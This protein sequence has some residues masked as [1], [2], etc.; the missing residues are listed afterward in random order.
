MKRFSRTLVHVLLISVIILSVCLVSCSSESPKI[1]ETTQVLDEV[2]LNAL[3]GASVNSSTLSFESTTEQLSS[4]SVGDV[5]VCGVSNVTPYGLLRKVTDIVTDDNQMT[6]ETVNAT[7]G[8]AIQDCSLDTSWRLQSDGSFAPLLTNEAGDSLATSAEALAT[9]YYL[10][11][12]GVVLYD[13]DGNLDTKDDQITTDLSVDLNIDVDIGWTISWFRLTEAH[14]QATISVTSE[15]ETSCTVAVLEIHPKLE[16]YRQYL[17]AFTVM[18][19]PVPVVIL[20]MLSINIG[21][22][23][24]LSAGITAGVTGN[25]EMTVGVQYLDGDWSPIADFSTSFDWQEPSLTAGCEVKVSAGPQL[26]LLLYGQA[27]P[28]VE[29]RGYLELDADIFRT[30]WWELYGGLEADVGFKVEA[31]SHTIAD[32]E[33]PL[34]I[35]YRLLLAQAT[36]ELP[37]IFPDPNLEA[38]IREAI[39]KPTGDIYPSDLQGLTTFYGWHKDITDLTGLEYCT[40]LAWLTFRNNQISDISPLVDNSGLGEGDTVDLRNNPLSSQSINLYIPQL[41]DRGITVYYVYNEKPK[42]YS[43]PP[44]MI[45]DTSKQYIATIETEKGNLVLELFAN[46]V[47]VTVNNF[48]FLAY[49]GFY[50]GLTFH[51][52]VPDFVAQ[53]GCPIGD[54]T[55]NPGYQFDDEITEHTHVTGALSMANAG[56]DT[57][58]C[59]FFITYTPQ[60]H[61]D[62]HHSVFGQLIEGMDVM[63]SFEEG[64]VIIQITISVGEMPE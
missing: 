29:V 51:R 3:S 7:L 61:L 11:L 12:D 57:N 17:T 58:G 32:Y 49:D 5:I 60:H 55:G 48:V 19:G 47:P 30:P 23:G 16:V 42:T 8:D 40:D 31:F 63:E 4:L 6:V 26:S 45:I 36:T 37:V 21:L 2:T 64:D 59:Q 24:E 9:G 56:P 14:L 52:V 34:A 10:Q 1:P 15:I 20:P 62:G 33:Y 18:V 13:N 39:D 27:G 50:D 44:P 38:A 54:G 53:G 43:E 35:G 28:Y 41:Q 22:D 46:D 25:A